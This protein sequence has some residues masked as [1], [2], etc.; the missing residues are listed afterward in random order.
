MPN[1]SSPGWNLVTSLPTAST[2]PATSAP[3]HGVLGRAEPEAR[4]AHRVGQAG[5]DVPDAPVHA[6]RAH[7]HQHLVVAD[8]G[9]V[10]VPELQDV[11]RAV[12][13]LDDRLH[14]LVDPRRF[15]SFPCASL[16]VEPPAA[17]TGRHEDV[18]TRSVSGLALSIC[19]WIRT[20]DLTIMSRGQR[21]AAV[22]G[23]QA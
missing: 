22:R 2:T 15:G 23:C 3:G 5:H 10:D 18:E 12:G 20:I 17:P 19:G 9:R 1:T 21:L 11:G 8:R 7:P 13:V 16:R 14:G 6:G 4:E